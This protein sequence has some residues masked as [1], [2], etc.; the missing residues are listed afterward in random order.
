MSCNLRLPQIS[1]LKQSEARSVCVQ[2]KNG[3]GKAAIWFYLWW[4]I[5]AYLVLDNVPAGGG[6]HISTLSLMRCICDGVYAPCNWGIALVVFMYLVSEDVCLV[7]FMSIP[8][9]WGCMSDGVY[10]YTLYLRMYLCLYLVSEDVCLV[11]FMY[12][13][14]PRMPGGLVDVGDPGLC[15]C[16]HV[17]SFEC[18]LTSLPQRRKF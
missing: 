2:S 12:L 15:S 16:V 7:V 6:V 4:S 17:R 11:V 5:A 13:V 9:I 1:I 8:C 18:S 14:F 10:V 3:M